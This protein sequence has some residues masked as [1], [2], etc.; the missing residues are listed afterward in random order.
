MGSDV[1][2]KDGW[3]SKERNVFSTGTQVVYHCLLSCCRLY[4]LSKYCYYPSLLH[5]HV[6]STTA[7]YTHCDMHT[8]GL[9]T[10]SSSLAVSWAISRLAFERSWA[11]LSSLSSSFSPSLVDRNFSTCQRMLVHKDGQLSQPT[12]T[13]WLTWEISLE[14]SAVSFLRSSLWRCCSSLHLTVSSSTWLSLEFSFT[15][16]FIEQFVLWGRGN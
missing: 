16:D 13:T 9:V 4:I 6:C 3:W 14:L 8:Q 11:S 15:L 10:F 5:V 1:Y 2:Q 12:S 7:K